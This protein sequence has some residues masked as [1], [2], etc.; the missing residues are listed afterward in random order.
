MHQ[1]NN[2]NGIRETIKNVLGRSGVPKTIRKILTHL[3]SA[4]QTESDTQKVI[5]NKT[6]RIRSKSFNTKRR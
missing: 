5:R 3:K 1:K 2:D 6:K 4:R